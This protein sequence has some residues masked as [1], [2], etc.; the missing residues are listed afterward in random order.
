MSYLNYDVGKEFEYY[1]DISSM[2]LLPRTS[3]AD[4]L[5]KL[6]NIPV[7]TPVNTLV[8]TPVNTLVTTP[9]NTLVTTPVNTPDN[10]LVNK[11]KH[12]YCPDNIYTCY[13]TNIEDR[14]K[15]RKK[16]YPIK[17]I[18]NK[19]CSNKKNKP[20]KHYK[21]L[22]DN[23]D[24][25]YHNV[26]DRDYCDYC[27]INNLDRCYYGNNRSCIYSEYDDDDLKYDDD[28]LKYDDDH[29][30]DDHDH[31]DDDSDYDTN[32]QTDYDIISD[33]NTDYGYMPGEYDASNEPADRKLMRLMCQSF[34]PVHH[35]NIESYNK[36]MKRI[37]SY[38]KTR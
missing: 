9:V 35:S 2:K 34:F 14:T 33:D 26:Y 7:N 31:D 17:S 3:F 21:S 24:D 30:D 4:A 16:Q 1:L 29:D 28:D 38:G 36:M 11:L 12:N 22:S 13:S 5:N 25:Y 15:S 37:N 10:T 23:S 8:T 6:V 19:H 18:K 20:S 27:Y 32:Y